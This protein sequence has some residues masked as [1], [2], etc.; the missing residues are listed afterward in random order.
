MSGSN[1]FWKNIRNTDAATHK[2]AISYQKILRKYIKAKLDTKFLKKCKS[3]TIYPKFV[4]WKNVKNKQLK[5]KNRQYHVNLVNP[6]QDRN[7]D[8]RSLTK[9]HDEM[10][11]Q[12]RQSTTW[13][14]Y[15]SI[16]YSLNRLQ[17]SKTCIIEKRHQ[18]K[19]D[20]LLI[21]KRLLDDIQQ[22]RNK[23]IANL[24]NIDLSNDEIS[25]LELGLKHGILKRSKEPEM[26]A[27]VENVW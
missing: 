18:K 27:I 9:K 11:I 21:E 14:K 2:L 15:H 5:D 24:T 17:S 12:L 7:N 25:T 20:N 6:L 13:M 16:I 19:Y 26:I 8:L 10:K 23:I 3:S 1:G 4:R 22:N